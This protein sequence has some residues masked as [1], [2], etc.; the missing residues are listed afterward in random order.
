[1]PSRRLGSRLYYE[2]TEVALSDGAAWGRLA[3]SV[4]VEV[5]RH[6]APR[7][8]PG[9][10]ASQQATAVE[11]A[12]PGA[13]G[14]AAPAEIVAAAAPAMRSPAAPDVGGSSMVHTTITSNT[15]TTNNYS[16]AINNS[17]T[18]NCGNRS[19]TLNFM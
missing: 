12:P 17:N 8:T 19:T 15:N 14:E 3:D 7:P 4:A 10:Q 1:M 2:F 13:V 6:G 9:S 5:R 11:A 16:N 18:N